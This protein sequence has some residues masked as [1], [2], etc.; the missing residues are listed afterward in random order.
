MNGAF[1]GAEAALQNCSYKKMFRK[2]ATNLQEN[3]RAEVW[4]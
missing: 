2:Y 4:F 1:L 3:N